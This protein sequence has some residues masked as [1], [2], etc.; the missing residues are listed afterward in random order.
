LC[1][2]LLHNYIANIKFVS[3]PIGVDTYT[4]MVFATAL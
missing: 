2:E 1:K 3:S 4:I